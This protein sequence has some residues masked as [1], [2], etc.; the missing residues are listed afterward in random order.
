MVR[1]QYDDAAFYIFAVSVLSVYAFPATY[2]AVGK[3]LRATVL[4]KPPTQRRLLEGEKEKSQRLRAKMAR[5]VWTN[6]FIAQLVVLAIV[7]LMLFILLSS[8]SAGGCV[9]T[10]LLMRLV[11]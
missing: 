3:I 1:V 10:N 8:Y 9:M 5:E 4:A 11:S 2:I 6:C 7:W